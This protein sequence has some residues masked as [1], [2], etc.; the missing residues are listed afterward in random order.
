MAE[1]LTKDNGI[2]FSTGLPTWASKG[3]P[4]PATGFPA[5]GGFVVQLPV[6]AGRRRRGRR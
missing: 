2:S 1:N 3:F 5:I 4:A 6:I